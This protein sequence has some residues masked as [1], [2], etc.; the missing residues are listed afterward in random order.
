MDKF[1]FGRYIPGHSWVHKLDP[2][3]KLVMSFMYIGVVFFANNFWTYLVMTAL[4]LV[5]VLATAIPIGV[6][7]RGLIPLFWLMIFTVLIQVFF[8]AGGHVYWQWGWLSVTHNGL[9]SA[10]LILMRFVLIILI[11][12]I[13]TFSTQPLA[14]ADGI[15]S[16]LSPLRKLHF[17]VATLALMLSLALRFVPT[18]MDEAEKIMNAQRSRGVD[19]GAGGL[20]QRIKTIVPIL[21]PLF[22]NAFNRAVDISTAMEARGYQDGEQRTK[23]RQ[24]KW[25]RADTI[26]FIVFV[27]SLSAV[28]VIRYMS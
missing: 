25:Q 23:Y 28:I 6:F 16:L 3:A 7:L 22:V 9:T 17:P 10:G 26:S 1:M 13:L 19:F 5:S 12:T 8:G 15:E 18:L 24:L 20:R 4:L 14:I 2:R 27:I 11:S 21:I